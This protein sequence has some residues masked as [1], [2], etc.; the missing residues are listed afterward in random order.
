MRTS[1]QHKHQPST[2]NP[3]ACRCP[4]HDVPLAGML[5]P[6][7]CCERCPHCGKRVAA[8]LFS[9]H[10]GECQKHGGLESLTRLIRPVW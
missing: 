5:H 2:G 7:P 4:C 1:R 8:G 3:E 9:R 6:Q 10:V